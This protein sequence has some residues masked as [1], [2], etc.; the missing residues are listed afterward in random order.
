[1]DTGDPVRGGRLLRGLQAKAGVRQ[2]EAAAE[3][4]D[5]RWHV[6]LLGCQRVHQAALGAASVQLDH[7]DLVE[8][9][10]HH[11]EGLGRSALR[12]GK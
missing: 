6:K 3:G 2:V 12:S 8:L 4:S 7:G 5:G 1:M 9:V 10:P 11:V